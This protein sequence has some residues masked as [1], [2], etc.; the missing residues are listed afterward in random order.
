[1]SLKA[2][3][4]VNKIM[5][6]LDKFLPLSYK[7]LGPQIVSV[8]IFKTFKSIRHFSMSVSDNLILRVG[9]MVD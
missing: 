8:D 5:T 9:E 2:M 4:V 6:K 1:V 3:I 7:N